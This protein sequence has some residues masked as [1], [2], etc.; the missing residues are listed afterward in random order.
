MC[1]H[2]IVYLLHEGIIIKHILYTKHIG[3]CFWVKTVSGLL[4]DSIY[5]DV[6]IFRA[7]MLQRRWSFFKGEQKL[8]S[9]LYSVTTWV[10]VQLSTR[11]GYILVSEKT[12][13]S[14]EMIDHAVCTTSLRVNRHSFQKEALNCSFRKGNFYNFFSWWHLLQNYPSLHCRGCPG[15][16]R[17][18]FLKV[19]AEKE[20]RVPIT[21]SMLSLRS[22]FYMEIGIILFGLGIW[23]N[24]VGMGHPFY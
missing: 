24:Y 19:P 23:D 21:H 17:F 1:I 2:C 15:G 14:V 10:T 20:C 11:W 7:Q 22:Q 12:K 5:Q 8:Q 18:G 13:T 3:F 4:A 16:I 6:K 9:F